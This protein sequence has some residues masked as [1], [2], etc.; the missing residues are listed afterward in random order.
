MLVGANLLAVD[1]WPLARLEAACGKAQFWR[2]RRR[3]AVFKG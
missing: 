2:V 3:R 1:V